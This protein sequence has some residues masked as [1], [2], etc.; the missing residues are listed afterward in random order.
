[1]SSSSSSGGCRGQPAVPPPG[2][3][4]SSS[5][6][7]GRGQ[8]AVR[9]PGG[10]GGGPSKEGIE[11]ELTAREKQELASEADAGLRAMKKKLYESRAWA[12]VHR[13]KL[14]LQSKTSKVLMKSIR[15]YNANAALSKQITE[16]EKI[17]RR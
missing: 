12:R 16:A 5:S 17:K 8:S 13:R 7:G 6:G 3:P 15:D 11:S 10:P 4:S 9:P 1:M 2:G 14:A